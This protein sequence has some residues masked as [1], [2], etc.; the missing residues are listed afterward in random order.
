M[1]QQTG[2][3][4]VTETTTANPLGEYAGRQVS[5]ATCEIRGTGSGLEK[6]M[7]MP[8][9]IL[10]PGGTYD[11]VLRCFVDKHRHDYDEDHDAFTLVNMLVA[12]TA[13]IV[14]PGEAADKALDEAADRIAER[15]AQ[16]EAAKRAAKGED[17][18]PFEAGQDPPDAAEQAIGDRTPLDDV[19]DLE[20][21]ADQGDEQ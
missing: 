8:P 7:H 6:S 5:R 16:A 10:E 1:E 15:R 17:P 4:T 2:D 19:A 18:L 9:Q 21:E 11:I 12:Q 3:Q 20:A 14:E 13:T